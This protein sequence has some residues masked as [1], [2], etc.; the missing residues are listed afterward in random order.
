MAFP[1]IALTTRV[2]AAEGKKRKT[3]LKWIF[4]QLL[5]LLLEIYSFFLLLFFDSVLTSSTRSFAR[6]SLNEGCTDSGGHQNCADKN[7]SEKVARTKKKNTAGRTE[8]FP[9]E[10]S[11]SILVQI[12]QLQVHTFVQK[13]VDQKKKKKNSPKEL[14]VPKILEGVVHEERSET[15]ESR[16]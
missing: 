13:Y 12:F 6:F 10:W 15:K 1:E 3:I 7:R 8:L 4:E 14:P 5:C 9:Q 11:S 16:K 2:G